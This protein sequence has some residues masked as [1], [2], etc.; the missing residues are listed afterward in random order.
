MAHSLSVHRPHRST[1]F[2]LLAASCALV[3]LQVCAVVV[4]SRVFDRGQTQA[5]RVA[6]YLHALPLGIGRVGM[7][8]LTWLA[9][10]CAVVS[11]ASGLAAGRLLGRSVKFGVFGLMTVNTLLIVWY[12]FTLM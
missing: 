8:G 12:L 10:L 11:M 1:G 9:F 3:V 5:E 2:A 4:W 7:S 6:L